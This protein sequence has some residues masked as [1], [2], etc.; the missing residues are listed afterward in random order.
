VS[1]RGGRWEAY[2]RG[3]RPAGGRLLAAVVIVLAVAGLLGWAL[4]H[5]HAGC[6][7]GPPI[8]FGSDQPGFHRIAGTPQRA[9]Q[10]LPVDVRLASELG[11][12]KGV[13][14]GGHGALI[15]YGPR[16]RYGVFRL[17]AQPLAYGF[18]AAAIRSLASECDVCDENRLVLLAPGVRGALMAGGNGPNSVSWVEN[19]LSMVVLG[20]SSSFDATRAIA[21]A[22]AVARANTR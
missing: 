6:A 17:T 10:R 19:G 14:K 2:A 7:C 20:P 21:A 8:S 4:A 5:P 12:P 1:I 18:G 9:I 22:R 3:P 11:P 16:S 15:L 13:Y